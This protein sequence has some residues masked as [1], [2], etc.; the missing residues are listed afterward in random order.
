MGIRPIP[1]MRNPGQLREE[2]G[3]GSWQALSSAQVLGKASAV[4]AAVETDADAD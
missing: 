4:T 2:D 3:R 1:E